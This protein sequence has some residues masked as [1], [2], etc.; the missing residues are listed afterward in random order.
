MRSDPQRADSAPAVR[1]MRSLLALA[2]P[3]VGVQLGIMLMGTVDVMMLGRLDATAL[4]AGAL[5]NAV[6]FGILMFP[7][8]VLLALDPL[9]AQAFGARDHDRIRRHFQRGL[10]LA[11]VLSLPAGLL[12]WN[13]EGA[14][15]LLGQKEPILTLASQYIRALIPGSVAFLL[16]AVLRQTLQSMSIVWPAL[17]TIAAANL[18]NVVANYALVFGNL[19]F[20]RL[21]VVGSAI[22]TSISRWCMF[23]GLSLIALPMLRRYLGGASW[24]DLRPVRYLHF[25][26][27]GLPVGL[28]VS[29]EM[30]VFGTVA[31]LMGSLGT[32]QLAGHQIALNLAALTFMIPLGI[33]G[34]AA[35]RVGNAIGRGD[36]AAGRLSAS[37][38]L[39]LGA[40]VMA[41]FA[42]LFWAA[43]A[44][45]SR[46]FTADSQVI[47]MAV[48]LL[49]IA[50]VFQVADGAQVVAAGVLRGTADTRWPALI[51]FFGYWLLGLPTGALLAYRYDWGPRG[52][53]WGLTLG[54][55]TVAVLFLLRIRSRFS[56]TIARLPAD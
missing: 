52:L 26:A 23:V 28:Q 30:W 7:F 18:V 46:L 6:G 20:P 55:A 35:T 2:A 54:L 25:L 3:V 56:T 48:L 24:A 22:A 21:E 37:V 32:V 49:P 33:A 41:L 14:L 11:V 53:W 10:V 34:A 43:P 19:G 47:R 40:G 44:A 31:L 5:G 51:A 9:V 29:L 42:L 17:A 27:I 36:Q 50:A 13:T 16:F 38:S 4:A 15:R 45:L 39:C 1:E 12:M 8:G